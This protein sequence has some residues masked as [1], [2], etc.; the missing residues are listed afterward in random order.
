MY[1]SAC[2]Q[3]KAKGVA[4][5]LP[6]DVVVANKFAADAE[7]KVCTAVV[8]MR[9]QY[10]H[11][12]ATTSTFIST[13]AISSPPLITP[14]PSPPFLLPRSPSGRTPLCHP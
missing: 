14:P 3:A 11:N 8:Y 10:H 6:E 7:F 9:R 1:L 13:K 12:I 2:P 4:L 5:L